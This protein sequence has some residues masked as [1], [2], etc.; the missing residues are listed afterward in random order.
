MG[1]RWAVLCR[2]R[3]S[4]LV[5]T[6]LAPLA[7][8]RC[9]PLGEI[10]ASAAPLRLVRGT[11]TGPYAARALGEGRVS[12]PSPTCSGAAPPAVF[13][14]G[15]EVLRAT[16]CPTSRLC[17]AAPCLLRRRCELRRARRPPTR[18]FRPRPTV[19]ALRSRSTQCGGRS[20]AR[21]VAGRRLEQAVGADGAA[22]R[23]RAWVCHMHGSCVVGH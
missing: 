5:T 10:H 8:Q 11:A 9:V 19:P 12:V 20:G 6:M 7:Q 16:G 18:P 21:R 22:L 1:M 2:R 23:S 14:A 13:A 4:V 3:G 17:R 15:G